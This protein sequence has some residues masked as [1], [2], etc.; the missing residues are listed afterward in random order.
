MISSMSSILIE[1]ISSPDSVVTFNNVKIDAT[2]VDETYYKRSMSMC[3][4]IPHFNNN[5]SF[6]GIYYL[7]YHSRR[8]N[9][10]ERGFKDMVEQPMDGVLNLIAAIG[11]GKKYAM[12]PTINDNFKIS[13]LVNL[14]PF[15]DLKQIKIAYKKLS[16]YLVKNDELS[17]F[18]N[19][20]DYI[21]IGELP[22]DPGWS[23][24]LTLFTI[25]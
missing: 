17:K 24:L 25:Y 4:S 3:D 6:D 12:L 21:F 11:R 18:E 5:C 23:M 20:P 16:C 1:N 10:L 22:N 14:K 13:D 7:N 19:K 9:N 2:N 15:K 8:C